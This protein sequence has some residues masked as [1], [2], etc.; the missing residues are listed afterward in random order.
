MKTFDV[1]ING[2][3]KKRLS[4]REQIKQDLMRRMKIKDARAE[5]L[6]NASSTR[7]AHNI[8]EEEAQRY[9]KGLQ[10]IG[11]ICLYMPSA[12]SAIKL[13]LHQMVEE[14]PDDNDI[15]SH[16]PNCEEMFPE[17]A[18][19]PPEKCGGCGVIIHKFL[20]I[21]AIEEEREQK[22]L[23]EKSDIKKQL[24]QSQGIKD[25]LEQQG[26]DELIEAR[27]KKQLEN[28]VKKELSI[29]QNHKQ[30][31]L[32]A[33]VVLIGAL[34]T[35]GYIYSNPADS[36]TVS[37][38]NNTELVLSEPLSSQE[39]L[40][41]THEKATKALGSFGMDS[42]S[43]TGSSHNILA[44]GGQTTTV[45]IEPIKFSA[46]LFDEKL[47]K[48]TWDHFLAQQV[49]VLIEQGEEARALQL[50]RH[51]SDTKIYID[52]LGQ[53]LV[54]TDEESLQTKVAIAIEAKITPLAVRQKIQFLAQ[55]SVYQ[56][57]ANKN[58]AFIEHAT[59]LRGSL[60]AP[61]E[62][63]EAILYLGVAHVQMANMDAANLY[64]SKIN[65][66]LAKVS[67]P[68]KKIH[69]R[70]LIAKSYKDAGSEASA[71]Q[72]LASTQKLVT[73][74]SPAS[75]TELVM[76]Y[77]YLGQLDTTARMILASPA[78]LAD[79]DL[80]YQAVQVFVDVGN[81]EQAE[82]LV[83]YMQESDFKASSYM[84]MSRD[85]QKNSAYLMSTEQLISQEMSESLNQAIMTSHLAFHY[86]AQKNTQKT[87]ALYPLTTEYL[88]TIPASTEK[89]KALAII[90][91]NYAH[92]L[93]PSYS[94]NLL[95][96]IQSPTIKSNVNLEISKAL[97]VAALI[98]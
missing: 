69:S 66:L 91:T 23:A 45:A 42:A 28:E 25:T 55:A 6:L 46:L 80:F 57:K 39:S 96:E 12:H 62:Q 24:L 95:N 17:A 9:Q 48:Q 4:E 5:Q 22:R 33:S 37:E 47:N 71:L 82:N 93:D 35:G 38:E 15:L 40:A 58:S 51:I 56:Y 85:R 52:S 94:K 70:I 19:L 65:S 34:A 20:A 97:Q 64:F 63:L 87:K 49:A 98:N 72:W 7:I 90:A 61:E 44:E 84:V 68:D 77:A 8:S 30:H 60:S 54:A 21:K 43:M 27:R 75:Y 2:I 89:D 29:R 81:P 76:A 78:E 86:S 88:K 31:M 18:E 32:A 73:E 41:A 14:K 59:Q 16:C 11:I 83:A 53:L 26:R 10:V 92:T 67:T 50:S 74:A 1:F 36:A 79:N 3:Q 13:D